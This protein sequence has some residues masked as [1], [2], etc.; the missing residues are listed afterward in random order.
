ML[1][2]SSTR[3][4][5]LF[6]AYP[7]AFRLIEAIVVLALNKLRKTNAHC[8]NFALFF[9]NNVGKRSIS[10]RNKKA[11]QNMD[12]NKDLMERFFKADTP[13]F[14]YPLLTEQKDANAKQL[15][16]ERPRLR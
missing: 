10:H 2:Q 1:H 16:M 4:H 5:G 14:Y 11:I 9:L 15:L 3:P 12:K 8:L 6:D 13:I 7:I